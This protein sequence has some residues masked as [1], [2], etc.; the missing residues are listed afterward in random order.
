MESSTSSAPPPMGPPLNLEL[1]QKGLGPFVL[2]STLFTVL[3]YLRTSGKDSF[4]WV[5]IK[6][7]PESPS[8]SP[9]HLA[10]L[11]LPGTLLIFPSPSQRLR[12]IHIL[13][14]PSPNLTLLYSTHVLASPFKPLTRGDV[15]RV[16][17]PTFDGGE[18]GEVWY[19]GLGFGFDEQASPNGGG[20]NQRVRSVHI[21]QKEE[22][23]TEGEVVFEGRRK[24]VQGEGLVKVVIQLPR[25]S[26]QLHFASSPP[27]TI[28]LNETTVSDL[29]AELGPPNRTF[30]KEDTR[31]SIHS[32]EAGGDSKEEEEGSYFQNYFQYG[33][34]FL[35]SGRSHKVY[36]IIMHSNLPGAIQFGRYERCP[37]EFEGD[38]DERSDPPSP[39]LSVTT[40]ASLLLASLSTPA[41]PSNSSSNW[42]TSVLKALSTPH[43]ANPSSLPLP[44]SPSPSPSP[45]PGTS[46]KKKKKD[47]KREA[48]PTTVPASLPVPAAAP[49]RRGRD[50]GFEPER[51]KGM[52]LDRAGEGWG[53]GVVLESTKL[54][55]VTEHLAFEVLGGNEGKNGGGDVESVV[56]F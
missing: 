51:M 26:L 8:T 32:E 3:D 6:F 25:L 17:G 2:G 48:Q 22:I 53:K 42:P 43:P 33:M 38:V 35:I 39:P 52:V 45:P 18:S 7:D 15:N 49:S 4:P 27:L 40:K 13:A 46:E 19:P 29:L 11:P 30:Y 21:C 9:I 50:G 1:T 47:S 54:I 34:D 36:K 16:F 23:G 41:A 10:L 14:L 55:A 20:R 31:M 28:T 12:Q 44:T 5:Q 24:V 37:W 56:L